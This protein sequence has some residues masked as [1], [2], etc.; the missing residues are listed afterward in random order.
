[1]GRRPSRPAVRRAKHAKEIFGG[2]RLLSF[3]F[4][5]AVLRVRG[6]LCGFRLRV[7]DIAA[8]AESLA[9]E[10]FVR[11]DGA[12]S[13]GRPSLRLWHFRHGA[14]RRTPYVPHREVRSAGNP[15]GAQRHR[16]WQAMDITCA[17]DRAATPDAQGRG[18]AAAGGAS[19]AVHGAGARPRLSLTFSLCHRERAGV[20]G[21]MSG[22]RPAV[23]RVPLRPGVRL[24]NEPNESGAFAVK[25]VADGNA[26]AFQPPR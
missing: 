16:I 15:L 26:A 3:R 24:R 23:R 12:A 17:R 4:V 19:P 22:A 5:P 7:R 2:R 20:R 1:M 10:G 25:A 9:R 14:W 18:G 11:N 13:P 21:G 8:S 6:V